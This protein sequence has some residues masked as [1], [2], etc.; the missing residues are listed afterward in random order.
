MTPLSLFQLS[1]RLSL[2]LFGLLSIWVAVW[3]TIIYDRLPQNHRWRKFNAWTRRD[4]I[5]IFV[6]CAGFGVALI[7]AALK[8]PSNAFGA[9]GGDIVVCSSPFFVVGTIACIR[10]TII[11]L[12][13][14]SRL[15]RQKS[16]EQDNGREC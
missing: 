4:R 11:E 13:L 2:L 12:R 6:L 15:R 1:G 8:V 16:L 10:I 3:S 14:A 5:Q 7:V 9:M